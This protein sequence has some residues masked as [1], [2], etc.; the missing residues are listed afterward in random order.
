MTRKSKKDQHLN[1]TKMCWISF[2]PK[3]VE[4]SNEKKVTF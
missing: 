3:E 4:Y 1:E 2:G